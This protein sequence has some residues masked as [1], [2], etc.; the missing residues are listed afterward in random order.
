MSACGEQGPSDEDVLREAGKLVKPLPGLYRSTTSLTAFD[1]TGADPRTEDMM[2]DR[3]AQIMPQ[4]RE[5][6]LT[7]EA[8][9]RGFED[10]IRQSQ[11]GDCAIHRFVANKSRLSAQMSC[12][13]GPKLSSTVAV[14][15]TGTPE[16]SHVDLEIVQTG[17]SVA[18]GS[19]T[20]GLSVDNE[21]VGDCPR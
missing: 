20:I 5:F 6:C 1:L 8:A 21:R 13:L 3:F 7:S 18:G 11:Q 9:A 15:G 12:R 10:M 19:E 17:P 4:R 16:R 2:R 14:E